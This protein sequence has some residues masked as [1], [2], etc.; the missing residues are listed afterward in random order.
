VREA[1]EGRST[2]RHIPTLDGLR[3]IAVLLVILYHCGARIPSTTGTYLLQRVLDLGWSGVDLFFVLS[4][5]LIT[6]ILLDTRESLSYFRTFYGRRVLRIFPLYFAYLTAVLLLVHPGPD[7]WSYLTYLSNWYFGQ[8]GRDLYVGHLW[9]LAIEEQFYLAWPAIVWLMP[10]RKLAWGCAGL[11]AVALACR[12]V[13]GMDALAAYRLTP[14]RMDGLALGAFVAIGM[15]EFRGTLDR[16]APATLAVSLTGLLLVVARLQS[17]F[18]NDPKM[19]TIG[20]S[21]VVIVYACVVF[22]AATARDGIYRRI[23][24]SRALG[25]FGKYSYAMY[26]FQIVVLARLEPFRLRLPGSDS[27]AF[28]G[29]FVL[30]CAAV[31]GVTLAAAWLSWRI[32]EHPFHRLRRFF[33]YRWPVAADGKRSEA[34]L[35]RV[36]V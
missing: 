27:P 17:G 16:W 18:W 36:T 20:A 30:Y 19:W 35:P 2:G 13:V 24:A 23:L 8:G 28:F 9:S 31:V 10:R 3:G 12:I 1:K 21:L 6:G 29:G 26:V 22:T 15:K 4:G 11:V 14:C 25:V 7:P 33:P 32:L 34:S 5:F